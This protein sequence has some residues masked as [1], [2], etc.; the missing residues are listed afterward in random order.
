VAAGGEGAP[1][2]PVY[3]WALAR[4]IGASEPVAF[5]NMG[6]VGNITWVNPLAE[7]PFAPGALLAFDTGPANA[8][9]NDL[10]QRRLGLS[11]D[12]DGALAGAG[13]V[14]QSVVEDFLADRFFTRRPPKSLDRD[15]FVRLGEAVGGLPDADAA[16]TLV[17]AAAAAV[18][19][20]VAW[21]PSPPSALYVTGG[22]RH[23]R[24]MMGDLAALLPCPVAPV[25]AVG[26]DGDM[27][28]AQAFAYMAVRA[29]RGLAISGPATTGVS[30]PLSG[31]QIAWP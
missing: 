8:P 4:Y 21:C 30:Q 26:L 9:V 27:L 14:L 3:H 31:G 11:V 24:T 29:A 25:E 1:L 22:G 15:A 5:L 20:A 12:Q 6:G 18:E 17:Y 16:A 23:N 7:D 28:E 19:K 2:A 10:M 13:T